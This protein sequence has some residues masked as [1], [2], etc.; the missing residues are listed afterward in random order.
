M[1]T[2]RNAG[3]VI[4]GAAAGVNQVP[5]QAPA[6]GMEMHVIP[7]ILKDGEVGKAMVEMDQAIT[8]V[9]QA[10]TA[11][12]EQQGVPREN[13]PAITMSNRLRN[14]TRMNPPVYTASK[15]VEDLQKVC[16]EAM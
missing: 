2:R 11:K 3:G 12:V 10:M 13:P 6:A 1:N 4:E 7:T 16:R 15:I 5:P 14:F 8:L 9:A